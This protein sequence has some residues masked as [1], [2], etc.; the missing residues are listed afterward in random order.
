ME[1]LET[2]AFVLAVLS[3]ALLLIPPGARS[4]SSPRKPIP[5]RVIGAGA[6]SS[7]GALYKTLH[8]A[9]RKLRQHLTAC[10]LKLASTSG[11]TGL[12]AARTYD[13]CLASR[14]F[15][16]WVAFSRMAPIGLDAGRRREGPAVVF[17]AGD[18]VVWQRW[19]TFRRR[20]D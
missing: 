1:A 8:D 19:S 4:S 11:R 16:L 17:P 14:P 7:S 6:C 2:Y 5:S 10:G 12:T 20:Q 13:G 15:R 9:R 18:R 3:V